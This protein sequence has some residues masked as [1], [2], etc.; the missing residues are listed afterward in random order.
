MR[1]TAPLAPVLVAVSE[2]VRDAT[3]ERLAGRAPRIEVIPNGIVV[4]DWAAAPPIDRAACGIP[5][6]AVRVGCVGRLAA[7]KDHE[8]VLEAVARLADANVHLLLI[9]DGERRAALAAAAAR[10]GIAAQVH[11]LGWRD[12][13][14]R[15][16]RSLDVFAM[17]SRYEGHSMALLEAMAA[18]CACLVS[19]I[20]ELRA[21]T[22]GSAWTAAAGDVDAWTRALRACIADPRARRERGA[23][24][25][26]IAARSAIES[27]AAAYSE[28]YARLLRA[29]VGSAR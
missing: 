4:Q 29:S 1:A 11:F 16:L 8:I 5:A 10:L 27:S 28:L 18:G 20:P 24:A 7:E 6:T 12:D 25:Q 22:D 17:P 19:D 26:R 23:A 15:W 3:R 9:G 13:V 21:Q 14:A 2:S